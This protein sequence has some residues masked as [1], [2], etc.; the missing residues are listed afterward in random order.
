MSQS[1]PTAEHGV[2]WPSNGV[3]AVPFRVYTDHDQ[4]HREQER[5]FQG[6]TWQY[7]CLEVELGKA[8]DFVSTTVGEAAVIVVR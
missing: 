6:P 8:G 7:L 1:G 2:S 5:L 3:S 4:Y